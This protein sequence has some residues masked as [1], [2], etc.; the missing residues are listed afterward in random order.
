[1]D[2]GSPLLEVRRENGTFRLAGEIDMSNAAE[3]A[4]KV[5]DAVR[6]G[7]RLVFDCAELRFIDSTG[8]AAIVEI[9]RG[10]GTSGSL[11]IRSAP[12]SLRKA[13]RVLGLDRLP[14]VEI[15]AG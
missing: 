9:S 5:A 13:V 14:N 2:T 11:V 1:M 8:M 3:F 4:G 7:N 10:L 12:H 6:D 15:D